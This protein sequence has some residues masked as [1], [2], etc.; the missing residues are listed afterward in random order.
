[1]SATGNEWGSRAES[2]ERMASPASD[3]KSKLITDPQ[4]EAECED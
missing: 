1:M 3:L 4:A 2:L